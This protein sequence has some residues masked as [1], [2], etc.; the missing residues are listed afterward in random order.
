MKKIAS[1]LII[2]ITLCL[3]SSVESYTLSVSHLPQ[4]QKGRAFLL[5]TDLSGMGPSIDVSFYDE[6][7]KAVAVVRK[8][9]LPKGK[10]QISVGDH[11]KSSGS[12]VVESSSKMVFAEY[13]Q[14]YKNQTVSVL[15]LQSSDGEER[16][17]LNC[18][19]FPSCEESYIAI[20]DPK[21]TGPMVQVEFYNKSGELVKITRKMLRPHGILVFK[22]GDYA[23]KDVVGKVSVRS[24]GGS[25]TLYTIYLCGKKAV[26]ALP[27]SRPYKN[28]IVEGLSSGKGT[29]SGIIIVDASSKGTHVNLELLDDSNETISS[30]ERSLSANSAILIDL[31]EFADNIE[32]GT[33]KINSES[34]IIANYWEE[35]LGT[36]NLMFDTAW[37]D[38]KPSVRYSEN[39]LSTS[40]LSFQDSAE[41]IVSILN[42]GGES[43]IGEIEIY[44]SEG[45]RIGTKKIPLE[46][47]KRFKESI[48]HYFGDLRLGT[49][50]VRDPNSSLLVTSSIVNTKNGRLFGKIQAISR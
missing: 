31:S 1:I 3:V 35:D 28:F 10:I 9:L 22:T 23:P 17:L 27:A 24:F 45:E 4:L 48:N 29:T 11:L 39:V 30:L 6:S 42:T 49:I 13:W 41:F 32:N 2:V 47:Y 38:P 12:I 5:I 16:Y 40:Y 14:V 15:P 26:F 44:N 36:G 43:V 19:R 20:C 25:I 50:V 21:G 33:I 18:F 8:L 7:G 37:N 46:P 34:E